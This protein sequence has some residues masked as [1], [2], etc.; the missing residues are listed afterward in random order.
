LS[1]F[2]ARLFRITEAKSELGR[3]IT[4]QNAVW[5]YKF[6]VQRRAAKKFK[7][8]QLADLNEGRLWLAMTQLRNTA[9]DETLIHDEELS[10]AEM[11]CRLLDAEEA[12][13]KPAEE[14]PPSVHDTVRGIQTAYDR[15]KDSEFGK[16]Y[17]EAVIEEQSTG[18]LLTVKAAI[19][20]VE[21]WSAIAFS[22]K[23]R[24]WYS[25]KVPHALDYQNLVHLI[26]PREE[27][28]NI[29]RGGDDILRKRVGFTLTDDRGPCATR[30]TRSTTA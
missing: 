22:T 14:Y 19:R 1:D 28:P 5:K 8:E 21:A 7:P 26:H 4:V 11:T 13:A 12:L 27:L 2:V 29:M 10:I 15:L 20:V 25:F 30:S 18:D 16:V 9:F 23:A 6:F 17:S 3:A 24:K